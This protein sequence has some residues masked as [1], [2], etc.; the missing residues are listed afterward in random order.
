MDCIPGAAIRGKG[1]KVHFK[2]GLPVCEYKFPVDIE[3]RKRDI[4]SGSN[5]GAGRADT[6]L[7]HCSAI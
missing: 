2:G 1:F 6:A 7:D 5:V 4:K 3:I